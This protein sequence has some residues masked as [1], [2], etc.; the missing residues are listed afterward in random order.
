MIA[1]LLLLSY[2]S[3]LL[4]NA[5]E[6]SYKL[7]GTWIKDCLIAVHENMFCRCSAIFCYEN[8]WHRTNQKEF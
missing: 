6:Y 1:V 5:T 2:K 3:L 8:F 4:C 7:I